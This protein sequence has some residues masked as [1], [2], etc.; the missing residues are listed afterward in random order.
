[1]ANFKVGDKVRILDGSQF[2]NCFG[3]VGSMECGIGKVRNISEIMPYGCKSHFYKLSGN[4]FVWDERG[5]EL[6]ESKDDSH[7]KFD[8]EAFKRGDVTVTFK[9]NESQRQFLKRCEAH[10]LKWASGDNPTAYSYG[11]S[12]LGNARC[13]S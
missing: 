9:T 5:L 12:A 11:N 13:V 10:G 3:W 1:M 4:E 2:E 6:V 8:W 7:D